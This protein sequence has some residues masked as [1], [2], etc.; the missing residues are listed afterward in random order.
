VSTELEQGPSWNRRRTGVLVVSAALATVALAYVLG[1]EAA[2]ALLARRTARTNALDRRAAMDGLELRSRAIEKRLPVYPPAAIARQVT[3]TTVVAIEVNRNGHVR[4]L[5]I[6]ESPD[7]AISDAVRTALAAW[8]FPPVRTSASGEPVT[9][10][11]RLVFYFRMKNG[12]PVVE[13]PLAV[14]FKAT[15]EE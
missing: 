7:A 12:L 9:V 14:P 2:N 11:S 13:E 8:R 5:E 3:G 10:E 4:I 15:R 6:L 1:L